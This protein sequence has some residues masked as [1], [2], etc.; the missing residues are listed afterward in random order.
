MMVSVPDRRDA[1]PCRWVLDGDRLIVANRSVAFTDVRSCRAAGYQERDINGLLLN[2]TVFVLAAAFILFEVTVLGA[3]TRFLLAVILLAGIACT[4]VQDILL[5]PRIRHY[6]VVIGLPGND[7]V[8]FT[9]ASAAEA[10]A[11]LALVRNRC[12]AALVG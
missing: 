12:P 3:R 1:P 8:V 11:L 4:S 10:E 6:R 2:F 7:R 5:S 9:T